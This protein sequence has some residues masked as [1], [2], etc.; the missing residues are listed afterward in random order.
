METLKFFLSEKGR[1][2][3]LQFLGAEALAYGFLAIMAIAIDFIVVRKEGPYSD[4]KIVFLAP[5]ILLSLYSLICLRVRR[6]HDIGWN[7]LSVLLFVVP[8]LNI[9]IGFI[10][11]FRKGN[12]NDN[13]YGPNPLKNTSL[14]SVIST[15][16]GWVFFIILI[17]LPVLAILFAIIQ[18]LIT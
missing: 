1:L 16:V 10:H 13:I 11:Y 17:S 3:R 2:S 9:F 7:G 5:F 8:I 6:F 14:I 15:Y 12:E 18:S 4:P